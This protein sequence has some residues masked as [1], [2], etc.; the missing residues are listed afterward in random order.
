MHRSTAHPPLARTCVIFNPT[1]R[2]DKARRLLR[3]LAQLGLQCAFKPTMA[4]GDARLLAAEAVREG[5]DTVVAVGGDG[6]IN[7]VI[8]GIADEPDGFAQVRLGVLPVGTVNVFAR[9]LGLPLNFRRAWEI[10][11]RG[12]ESLIDLPHVE[13][14]APDGP[15]RRWF[16]QMAG[17]GLDARAVE[18]MDWELKKK[19]GRIAYLVAGWRALRETTSRILVSDG[20][21]QFDGQLVL[22]GNGRLYGGSIPVFRKANPCDGLLDV[23]VFPRVNWFVILRYA[24][25]ALSPR[26]LHSG[27]ENH[28][29]ALSVKVECAAPAPLELDGEHVG[30]SPATFSVRRGALRVIVP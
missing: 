2:G 6:T 26:L 7:E 25:A 21:H 8:N 13:F 9:E 5:C 23:C 14:L 11:G 15:Q 16:A 20:H 10:V 27:G 28:F 30:H 4:A 24:C 12:R 22:L 18:L 19:I 3:H 1:A 17:C 29:Q